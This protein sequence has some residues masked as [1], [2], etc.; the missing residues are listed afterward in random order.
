MWHRIGKVH[1]Q[2]VIVT[3][4]ISLRLLYWTWWVQWVEFKK[5]QPRREQHQNPIC[6][7][8]LP[9]PSPSCDWSQNKQQGQNREECSR[10]LHEST[11]TQ[12]P[13]VVSPEVKRQ[14][15]LTIVF[16]SPAENCVTKRWLKTAQLPN[17]LRQDEIAVSDTLTA[18]QEALSLANTKEREDLTCTNI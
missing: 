4:S 1:W 7:G 13:T 10:G 14:P 11:K 12:A 5:Y 3:H 18:A 6:L 2:R 16:Q 15:P 9:S 17:P 8:K